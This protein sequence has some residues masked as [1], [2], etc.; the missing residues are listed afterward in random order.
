[1][2]RFLTYAI[3]GMALLVIGCDNGE[4]YGSQGP[5]IGF[6]VSAVEASSRAGLT[7]EDVED[8]RVYVYG[9]QNSTTSLYSGAAITK[10]PDTGR[11]YPSTIRRWVTG[12]NYSFY[13][14]AYSTDSGLTIKDDGMTIEVSQ[15]ASYDYAAEAAGNSP[16]ID[17][18]L[19]YSFKV[20]DGRMRPLVDLQLEHAMT[21]VDIR[22]VKDPSISGVILTNMTLKNIFRSGTMKCTAQAITNSGDKNTW[23]VAFNGSNDATYSINGTFADGYSV[24]ESVADTEAKMSIMALPQQLTANATLTITY[25][26]NEKSD[27]SAAEDNWVLHENTFRLYEYTPYVWQSGHHVVYQATI[28]TGIHLQGTVADWINVDYIEGTIMPEI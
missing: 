13:G 1:M 24:S 25:Y 18:L 10:D 5:E 6:G 23:S 20:A 27:P 3:V 15:P 8:M 4:D 12:A 9:V 7:Q 19:S 11:W 14:Y 16:F 21:L 28:D 2:S 22:V 26:V 17:Y